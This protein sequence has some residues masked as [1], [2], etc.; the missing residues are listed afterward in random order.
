MNMYKQINRQNRAAFYQT[1]LI[2]NK[3]ESTSWGKK[4]NVVDPPHVL[5]FVSCVCVCVC[6]CVCEYLSKHVTFNGKGSF[7]EA[8]QRKTPH[9]E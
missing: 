8:F 3:L 7:R 1:K 5:V 4:N 2:T 6:V 9:L